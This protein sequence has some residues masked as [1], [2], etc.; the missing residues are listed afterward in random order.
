MVTHAESEKVNFLEQFRKNWPIVAFITTLITSLVF[1]WANIQNNLKVNE[2]DIA[3]L[4]VDLVAIE[5]KIESYKAEVSNIS[6]DI[7]AI[8]ESLS[9]IRDR[10]TK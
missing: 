3:Q 5:V 10:L 4:R 9:F 7:K 8:K 2:K 1:G 6:G